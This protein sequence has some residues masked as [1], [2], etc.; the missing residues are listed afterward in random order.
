[1]CSDLLGR[2]YQRPL[3][4]SLTAFVISRARTSRRVCSHGSV[5]QDDCK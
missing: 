1:L 3:W 5:E 4:L 2:H